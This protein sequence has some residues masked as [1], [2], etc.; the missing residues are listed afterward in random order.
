MGRLHHR[1]DKARLSPG[2]KFHLCE[3]RARRVLCF[4]ATSDASDSP[5]CSLHGVVNSCLLGV[6]TSVEMIVPPLFRI[7]F[8]LTVLSGGGLGTM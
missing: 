2:E 5:C 3:T 6:Q 8:V 7:L 4:F 1:R